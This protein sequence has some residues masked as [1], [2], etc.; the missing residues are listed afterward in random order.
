MEDVLKDLPNQIY[1]KFLLLY[2][3]LASVLIGDILFKKC[4][5]LEYS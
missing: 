3:V 2:G 1:S 5:I 4:F